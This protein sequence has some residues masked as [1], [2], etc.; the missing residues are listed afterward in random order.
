MWW[1]VEWDGA[2]SALW[3]WRGV[4]ACRKCVRRAKRGVA[5]RAWIIVKCKYNERF[6]TGTMMAWYRAV[7]V[8]SCCRKRGTFAIHVVDFMFYH[9][10]SS[11]SSLVP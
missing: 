5:E 4:G 10:L 8:A 11:L 7:G 6:P 3:A 9:R 2:F 1:R